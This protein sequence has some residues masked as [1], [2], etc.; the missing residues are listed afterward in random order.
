VVPSTTVV[1]DFP[2]SVVDRV[3][4]RRGARKLAEAYQ[5]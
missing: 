1:A 2:V 4:D 5:N 3:A